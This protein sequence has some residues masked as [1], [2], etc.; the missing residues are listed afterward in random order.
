MYLNHEVK[1]FAEN[2][3]PTDSGQIPTGAIES[4]ANTPLD[5]TEQK[6]IGKEIDSDFEP[7]IVGSGYDHNYVINDWDGSL[8]KTAELVG[9]NGMKMLVRTTEPGVQLYTGNH[10]GGETGKKGFVHNRNAGVC[11]ETQHF[12]DSPN[13]PEFPSSVVEAGE[14]FHS[15]TEY[16]FQQ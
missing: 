14:M 16:E 13:R 4:V 7:I 12:P 10:L 15:V 2:Y 6:P 1:I 5:F 3:T 8:K 11:L 9:S